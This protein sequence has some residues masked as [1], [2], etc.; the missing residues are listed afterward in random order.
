M[1][2]TSAKIGYGATFQTDYT[3]ASPAVW[4]T[5]SEVTGMSLPELSRDA[6]DASHECAPN[7]W[8]T[9]VTGLNQAGEVEL[10]F[11]FTK[12]QYQ[13]LQGELATQT[14]KPRRIVLL[15]GTLM[16][17]SATLI[18]LALPIAIGD[19]LMATA[20]FKPDGQPGSLT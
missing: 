8:R 18:S 16:T 12:A 17:F 4:V 20:K 14:S 19:R 3:L 11:N 1:V 10:Q 9:F 5:L 13:T 6:I 15:D 2:A 7:E